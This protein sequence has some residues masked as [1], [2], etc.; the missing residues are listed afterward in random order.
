MLS[1]FSG[2][3]RVTNDGQLCAIVDSSAG[4]S[5]AYTGVRVAMFPGSTELLNQSSLDV[6][7]LLMYAAAARSDGHQGMVPVQAAPVGR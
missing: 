6:T 5:A 7:N 1:M 2:K 4:L 3:W